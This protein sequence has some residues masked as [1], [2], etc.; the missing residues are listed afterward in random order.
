MQNLRAATY[1][2][3]RAWPSFR[4]HGEISQQEQRFDVSENTLSCQSSFRTQHTQHKR[5]TE[6]RTHTHLHRHIHTDTQ[7]KPSSVRH[8]KYFGKC[9]SCWWGARVGLGLGFCSLGAQFVGY[10][11]C[12]GTRCLQGWGGVCRCHNI[13]EWHFWTLTVA[14]VALPQLIFLNADRQTAGQ[15]GKQSVRQLVDAFAHHFLSKS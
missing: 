7:V 14:D 15:A 4:H 11:A 3:F 9:F 12:S 13:V 8:W 2:H 6:T 1:A 5:H 10:S